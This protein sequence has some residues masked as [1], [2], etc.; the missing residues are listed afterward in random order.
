MAVR[1]VV[2]SNLPS[3]GI[4]QRVEG[5]NRGRQR[6][7]S[8][9]FRTV[10]L[11]LIDG[12]R[13][14]VIPRLKAR[15]PVRS[16]DLRRSLRIERRGVHHAVVGLDY[17]LLVREKRRLGQVRR[18]TLREVLQDEI[19]RAWPTLVRAAADRARDAARAATQGGGT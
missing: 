1:V 12:I 19:A 6:G 17:G 7:V 18:F 13:R 14:T 11:A 16:G 15:T 9:R 10:T 5:D 8:D 4:A 2:S 3:G